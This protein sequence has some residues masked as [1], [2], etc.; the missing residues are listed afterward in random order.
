[1]NHDD[2]RD[3]ADALRRVAP[4]PVVPAGLVAGA[5]RK[6]ARA[7][8][9]VGALGGVGVLALAVGLGAA[10][11]LGV[12]GSAGSLGSPGDQSAMSQ[13]S[14]APDGGGAAL[15]GLVDADPVEADLEAAAGNAQRLGWEVVLAGG[16]GNQ[17]VSP[18][19]LSLSLAMTAE[20]ARGRS[21]ESIDAALGLSGDA[22]AE[23]HAGLRS[24][25]GGYAAAPGEI[26]LEEP[27]VPPAVHL[28]NRL[29]TIDS[30]AEQAFVDRLAEVYG[31]ALVGTTHGEAQS[32]LDSW[33]RENTAGLIE[34]SGIE[35]TPDTRVVIQDALLFAAAWRT[36]FTSDGVPL[37]FDGAGTIDAVQGIVAARY[38]S[39]ERWSAVRLPYD[40]R[41]A[42]DV[43]LPA[44]GLSPHDLTVDDLEDAAEAL[45]AAP[46]QQIDVTMPELDLTAKT[47][48]LEALPDVDLSDLGGIIPDGTVEQWVQQAVL[49]VSAQG[50]VGAAVTEV[51]VAESLPL[52]DRSFVADRGYAFRVTDTSTGWPLFLASVVDPQG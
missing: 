47:D 37:E 24:S 49:K 28:A 3:V 2:E 35:V 45:D 34:R 29:V 13:A 14:A 4:D 5:R 19:S 8:A 26:D 51:A 38:V 22:R 50:T 12:N 39:N 10:T 7:M 9:K 20:G 21:L 15:T 31:V 18:S 43:I 52:S 36:P 25:L 30:D 40:E 46:E 41:L 17:V 27:P 23:A 32:L 16:G 1:M 48:L 11:L 42:A 44:E 6:R 33:V